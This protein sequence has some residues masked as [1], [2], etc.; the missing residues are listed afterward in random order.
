M[1]RS[2]SF[3]MEQF[4]SVSILIVSIGILVGLIVIGV[5][6]F[7]M[8]K[9]TSEPTKYTVGFI[10]SNF[11]AGTG[12]LIPSSM[13]AMFKSTATGGWSSSR[14]S[15][16]EDLQAIRALESISSSANMGFFGEFMPPAMAVTIVGCVFIVGLVAYIRGLYLIRYLG[17]PDGRAPTGPVGVGKVLAHI[18]GGLVCM[19]ILG[20]GCLLGVSSFCG[21]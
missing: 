14:L 10:I 2:V 6:V 16:S 13:Y 12:L 7:A 19:D 4:E 18:F 1:N 8:Y 20:A 3:M 9:H 15:L 5:G 21:A 17:A 11:V